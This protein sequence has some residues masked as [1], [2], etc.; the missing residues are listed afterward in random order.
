MDRRIDGAVILDEASFHRELAKVIEL[1]GYYGKNLDAL[2][3]V[4]T[5]DVPGPLVLIW[6]NSEVSRMGMTERFDLIVKVLRKVE[7]RD[8]EAGRVDAFRLILA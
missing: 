6:E 3:D 5:V 8:I 1:P 4:M 2:W 7:L